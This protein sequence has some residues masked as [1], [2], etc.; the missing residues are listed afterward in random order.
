MPIKPILFN[1]EM[2]KAILEGRK[3]VTRRVIKRDTQMILSGPFKQSHPDMPDKQIIERICLPRYDAG[4]ILYVRETWYYETHMHGHTAGKPDLTSGNYS[5]RYIYRAD[6]PDFP[7][8]VGVGNHGWRPSIHM[9]KEASRIFLKVTG[10]R[11]ERLQEITGAGALAEGVE[12]ESFDVGNDF[13]RGMF[14]DIWDSTIKLSE[15]DKYSWDAN[16]WVWVIEFERCKKP[17]V[18]V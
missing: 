3:T 13:A 2:V 1:T 16:P 6:N 18:T 4:D 8:D 17:G 15:R 7:V 5:H 11:A 10:V 12:R 9:P 14:S